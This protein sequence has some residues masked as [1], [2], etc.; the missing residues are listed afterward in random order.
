MKGNQGKMKEGCGESEWIRARRE[1]GQDDV[2]QKVPG[3]ARRN[4]RRREKKGIERGGNMGM[5]RLFRGLRNGVG[6]IVEDAEA[7]AGEVLA[8]FDLTPDCIHRVVELDLE[9]D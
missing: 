6:E 9:A 7:E 2:I 8:M 3:G 5:R 1:H 4:S